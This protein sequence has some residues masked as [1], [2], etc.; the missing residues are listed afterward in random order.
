VT[1]PETLAERSHPPGWVDR[2]DSTEMVQAI[3]EPFG[4]SIAEDAAML[5][6]VA[7][8]GFAGTLRVSGFRPREFSEL[9]VL[10]AGEWRQAVAWGWRKIMRSIGRG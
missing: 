3:H 2:L 9:A 5:L 1:I 8:S 10:L 7:R 4:H 6:L